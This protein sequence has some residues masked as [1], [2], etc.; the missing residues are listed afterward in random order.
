M[1]VVIC[2]VLICDRFSV[3]MSVE[4]LLSFFCSSS[5]IVEVTTVQ[6]LP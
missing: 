1:T 4:N 2:R 5:Y 3:L 6:C